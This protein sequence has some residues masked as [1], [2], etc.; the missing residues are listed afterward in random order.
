MARGTVLAD[1]AYGSNTAWRDA[2]ACL[3]LNYAVGIVSSVKV[4]PP[5]QRPE[6]PA[7]WKGQGR[8]PVRHRRTADHQPQSV[9]ALALSL[10][11]RAFR[12]VAWREG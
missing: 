2:L 3:E 9:Q 11:S 10:P 12:T 1:A 6:S 7:A 8:P 4:W 5:G